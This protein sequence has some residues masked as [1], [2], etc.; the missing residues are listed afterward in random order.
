MKLLRHLT[1]DTITSVY[2]LQTE[3]WLWREYFNMTT[4][5]TTISQ[6]DLKT[7]FPYIN[8]QISKLQLRE[9]FHVAANR[10][11]D[12]LTFEEFTSLYQSLI[13][14]ENVYN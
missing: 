4:D 10:M 12:E 6:K 7:F 2:P 11:T 13:F 1:S 8:L 5:K 3:R 9:A 14:D